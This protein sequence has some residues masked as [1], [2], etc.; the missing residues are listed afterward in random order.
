[1]VG[2]SL[3]FCNCSKETNSKIV[4]AELIEYF[5]LFEEEAAKFDK[6]I[7]LSTLDIGGM[8]EN[9]EVNGVLGQCISYS[10]GTKDVVVDAKYWEGLNGLEKEYIIFHELGH[11]VL[12]RSHVNESGT[13]RT[14]KSIMQNGEAQCILKYNIDNRSD[15]LEELFTNK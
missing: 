11:C 2:S 4:E 1:M 10:D 3:L 14:C 9:I 13:D 12:Q 7:D 5:D 15:L 6:E 8:V